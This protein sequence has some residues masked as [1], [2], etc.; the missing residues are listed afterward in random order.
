MKEHEHKGVDATV[1]GVDPS[2][3]PVNA[4]IVSD[5]RDT[6]GRRL[7][8]LSF[9]I[10]ILFFAMN[11]YI[12]S[13]KNGHDLKDAKHDRSTLIQAVNAQTTYITQL[14]DAL[15]EQNKILKAAGYKTVQVPVYKG[16]KFIIRNSP[17]PSPQ[18]ES[19]PSPTSKP[20]HKPSSKPSPK[21]SPSPTDDVK[22]RVCQLTG[23]CLFLVQF[24]FSL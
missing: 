4:N 1:I 23:I 8:F 13:A 5:K 2:L 22:S 3:P 18:P 24:H 6:L 14:Q 17:Q 12:Q 21:P 11:G 20:S 10:L 7:G 19:S 15:R 9:A 16:P